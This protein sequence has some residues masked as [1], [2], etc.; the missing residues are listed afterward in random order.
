MTE[1]VLGSHGEETNY[2]G[3]GN[4]KSTFL[5]ESVCAHTYNPHAA[6]WVLNHGFGLGLRFVC[7]ARNTVSVS[8]GVRNQISA[9]RNSSKRSRLVRMSS[10]DNTGNNGE[11]NYRLESDR[12]SL[13]LWWRFQEEQAKQ[14]KQE[15]EEQAEKAKGTTGVIAS[16]Q[17]AGCKTCKS[18]G[19]VECKWCMGT[20]LLTLGDSLLC[21]LE[22]K[23]SVCP[24]CKSSGELK[25][26]DCKGTGFVANWLTSP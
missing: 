23:S 20:G 18:T 21:S 12:R 25:C 17:F 14:R 11:E 26:P 1:R 7:S 2:C 9:V 5:S 8:K 13:E 19:K 10:A 24:C 16:S 6:G 3:S 15:Q 4:P 22:T